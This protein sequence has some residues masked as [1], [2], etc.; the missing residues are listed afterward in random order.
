MAPKYCKKGSPARVEFS[1]LNHL[2]ETQLPSWV[3]KWSN[4]ER[5]QDSR[6]PVLFFCREPVPNRVRGPHPLHRSVPSIQG[7]VVKGAAGV[8]AWDFAGKGTG[9]RT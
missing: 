7:V 4:E 6:F 2:S 5:S 9:I 8:G 1:A 3:R